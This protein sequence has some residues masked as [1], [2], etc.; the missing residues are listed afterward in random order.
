MGYQ[1]LAV[2]SSAVALTIPNGARIVYLYV[3]GNDIRWRD[4]GTNPTTSVGSPLTADT[5][6][7]YDSNLTKIRFIAQASDATVHCTYYA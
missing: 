3:E 7:I 6:L 5:D 2:S 1:A 4:D